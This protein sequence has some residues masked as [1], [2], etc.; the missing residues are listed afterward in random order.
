MLET[1]R[2]LA[3]CAAELDSL[4]GPEQVWRSTDRDVLSAVVELSRTRSALDG[5]H[6][7]LVREV[8]AR[9]VATA[10][11]VATSPEGFLRSSCLVGAAQARRDVV[12]ARA[13][14]PGEVLEPLARLLQDGRCTR[15]HVDQA[16]RVLDC[17]PEE[18]RERPGAG[19]L[20]SD[21]L[22]VAARDASPLDL[23]HAGQ[24]L[25]RT[26]LPEPD[27]RLDRLSHQRR[28][29]DLAT[30]ATGMTVGRLQLDPVAGAALRTALQRWSGP[31]SGADG[32]PDTRGPR[33]RRADALSALVDS[34]LAVQQP[35]RGERPRVVLHMTPDQLTDIRTRSDEAA[36]TRLGGLGGPD[37]PRGGAGAAGMPEVEGQGPVPA[38]AARRLVCD[39][40]L[41]RVVAAPSEGPLDVGRTERLA[42]L[43]Q[44]RALAARDGGCVVPGC[45]AAPDICDAHHV[46]HWVDGGRTDL[47]N[48]VLLCPG[49]HTAVHAGTWGVAVD[50][51]HQVTV[52]PPR[53]VDPERRPRP[54]WS[55]R[56]RQMRDELSRRLASEA[57]HSS[58]IDE[59]R[60]EDCLGEDR[61]HHPP[62]ADPPSAHPLAA[63]SLIAGPF[64]QNLFHDEATAETLPGRDPS[65]EG[66]EG[67]SPTG[68][69]M[70][71]AER[72]EENLFDPGS[73]GNPSRHP[74]MRAE[75][76]PP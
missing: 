3:A 58:P 70:S 75:A 44:R 9:G 63:N 21:Y 55:Q 1:L 27:E 45:G 38:W 71:R 32:E 68:H 59:A 51:A 5:A 42:T 34:A 39:A 8:D 40:V 12:A 69:D 10:S 13:T 64:S 26:L 4:L 11:P 60:G 17:I 16:V 47:V 30:D 19:E 49:H 61:P 66:Q 54:A 73:V 14:A 24:Q 74:G 20:I 50:D 67:R 62:G 36:T 46:V 6:L 2:R 65:A 56:A 25:V 23:Q 76:L 33:Q 52:T 37:D 57:P 18:V 41:Q 35:R 43:A 15:G 72:G 48:L 53:W 22:L 29:L 31:E 28:F 7:R